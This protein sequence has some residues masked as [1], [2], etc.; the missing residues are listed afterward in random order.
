MIWDKLNEQ[1]WKKVAPYADT[2]LIPVMNIDLE[3]KAEL[4]YQR[5]DSL[6]TAAEIE[7]QLTGRVLLLPPVAYIANETWF[8]SYITSIRRQGE[9]GGFR[10]LFFL[11]DEKVLEVT[12][13]IDWG[14]HLSI[15]EQRDSVAQIQQLC[16]QIVQKWQKEV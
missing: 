12:P 4:E 1:D 5:K 13:H 15:S 16:E 2:L 6:H 10:H 9:V 14:A 7:R 8:Q 3:N 11:L